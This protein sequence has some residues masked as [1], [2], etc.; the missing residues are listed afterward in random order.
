[1]ANIDQLFAAPAKYDHPRLRSWCSYKHSPDTTRCRVEMRR[2]RW[3]LTGGLP[4]LYFEADRKDGLVFVD[5]EPWEEEFNT[6]LVEQGFQAID[7]G[8]EGKRFG[9]ALEERLLRL[10]FRFGDFFFNAVTMNYLKDNGYGLDPVIASKLAEIKDY[11]PQQGDV[12]TDCEERLE[13]ALGR[14][15]KELAGLG[16]EPA[17]GKRILNAAIAYYLDDRFCITSRAAVGWK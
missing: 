8:N 12:A 16:Y 7:E 13:N 17:A 14:C 11:E 10:S 15:V 3:G 5:R 9:Y 2:E 1:M 4:T 6:A